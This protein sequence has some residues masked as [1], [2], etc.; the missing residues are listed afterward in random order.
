MRLGEEGRK[1]SL[2]RSVVAAMM[3]RERERE[4]EHSRKQHS[5]GVSAE[6]L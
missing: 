4:R 3:R 5:N 6:K 2:S 1:E